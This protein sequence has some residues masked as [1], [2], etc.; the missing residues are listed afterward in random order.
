MQ[1]VS[2]G[3]YTFKVHQKATKKDIARA[4][5]KYFKV[6]VRQVKTISVRGKKRRVGRFRQVIKLPD[7]KKAMVRLAPEE[8][9]DVFD[10]ASERKK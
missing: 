3:E 9:I 7:W 6:D 2:S 4:V 5:E 1:Q 10:I 8:K